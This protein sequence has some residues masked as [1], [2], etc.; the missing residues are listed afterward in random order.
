MKN[1]SMFFLL[2]LTCLALLPM[3][4]Y[5]DTI[6]ITLTASGLGL[7]SAAINDGS[8]IDAN[9][10]GKLETGGPGTGGTVLYV[11]TDGKAG[12]NTS[13]LVAITTET[14]LDVTTGYPSAWLGSTH[15]Y[16]AGVIYL[17][18]GATDK[19]GDPVIKDQGLGVKAFTITA[20]T[21]V[22]DGY[23]YDKDLTKDDNK[24]GDKTNDW[25]IEGSKEVSGGTDTSSYDPAS[26]NG[27]PHVDEAVYFNFN[28]AV[29]NVSV[30]L[31]D[32]ENTDRFWLNINNGAYEG[33][34]LN[35]TAG[36][37]DSGNGALTLDLADFYS[38][39][40][41]TFYIRAVDDVPTAPAGTAEHFLINGLIVDT[42]QVP[43]PSTL[44]LLGSGMVGLAAFLR[45]RR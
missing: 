7:G 44:L 30:L 6:S 14:H 17:T 3:A 37:F 12:S 24:D 38:G 4:A 13:P 25:L 43:E 42:T 9:I 18:A 32:F 36:T 10:P 45:K 29:T 35:Y 2:F 8:P 21:T 19:N 40:I 5:A 23:R 31:T 16:Q 28:G 20:G 1:R 26:P 39:P 33:T 15:D 41:T 27:A 22:N 34:F 11:G